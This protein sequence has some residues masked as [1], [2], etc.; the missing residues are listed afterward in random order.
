MLVVW[1]RVGVDVGSRK[2]KLAVGGRALIEVRTG[3]M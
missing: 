2:T 1:E 3:L